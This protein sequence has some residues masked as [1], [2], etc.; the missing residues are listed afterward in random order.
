MTWWHWLQQVRA[1]IDASAYNEALTPARE[2][3]RREC[4]T[5]RQS[6]IMLGTVYQQLGDYGKAVPELEVGATKAP[7]NFEARYQ[8]G[9]V[10]A[11]MEKPTAGPAS[12]CRKAVALKPEDRAA[13]YQLVAVLCARLGRLRK[14]RRLA[15]QLRS[16]QGKESL[17]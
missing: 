17:E 8:L 9:L 7:D 3:V 5:M 6:H 11:R 12:P 10:L 13:K 4:R 2:Y 16:E 1:L 14:Q 15:G